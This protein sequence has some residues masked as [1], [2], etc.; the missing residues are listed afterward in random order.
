MS[1][2]IW[3]RL[4]RDTTG[5][6]AAATTE[7]AV[8]KASHD[9]STT[10]SDSRP[11]GRPRGSRLSR[12]KAISGTATVAAAATA[13]TATTIA[14]RA[15]VAGLT[16]TRPTRAPAAIHTSIAVSHSVIRVPHRI[17]GPRRLRPGC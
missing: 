14:T 2:A 9:A 15:V 10:P 7:V 6:A 8:T 13:A 16:S 1:I 5:H 3:R 17:E 12:A 11:G 4:R